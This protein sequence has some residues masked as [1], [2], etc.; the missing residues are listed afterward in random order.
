MI[1]RCFSELEVSERKNHRQ[2]S[3]FTDE[4]F[5]RRP[6][7]HHRVCPP[8]IFSHISHC[9]PDRCRSICAARMYRSLSKHGS[10]TEY[11]YA[12]CIQTTSNPLSYCF[13]F[14]KTFKSRS[15]PPQFSERLPLS[16]YQ[17]REAHGVHSTMHFMT[18]GKVTQS[19]RMMVEP[20]VFIPAEQI[21]PESV[22]GP[23]NTTPAVLAKTKSKDIPA[24]QTSWHPPG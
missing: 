24:Y 19:D 6:S 9:L 20:F 11:S 15:D 2:E 3:N 8:W 23:S 7:S 1:Y 17:R 13:F 21:Q 10:L 22:P 14:L 16:N 18:A 12:Q 5:L 4:L